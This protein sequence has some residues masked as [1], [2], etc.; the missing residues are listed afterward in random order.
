M[1]YFIQYSGCTAKEVD[2]MSRSYRKNPVFK[3]TNQNRHSARAGKQNANRRVRHRADVLNNASYK[4]AYCSWAICDIR[5]RR[6]EHELR[7]QWET[8]GALYH[9][10]LHSRF[11]TYKQALWWWRKRY[12]GK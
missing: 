4:K 10:Y 9:D 2:H 12:T 7:M 6:T 3:D 1:I 11:R 8:K 5:I